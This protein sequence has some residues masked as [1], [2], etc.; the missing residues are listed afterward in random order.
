MASSKGVEDIEKSLPFQIR[1]WRVQ[2]VAWWILVLF[3]VAAFLGLLGR[4][5]PLSQAIVGDSQ[6][7]VR[8]E[9]ER[10]A[11]NQAPQELRL[12]MYVADAS[13]V[14]VHVWLS[15]RY[16]QVIE[17]NAVAPEPE[18]VRAAGQ[19]LIYTFSKEKGVAHVDATFF[20]KAHGFGPLQGQVGIP[21]RM[22]HDFYQF[23]YP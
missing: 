10:F 23:V 5:G 18:T 3:W 22:Q 16:L 6:S 13:Q 17:V 1:Q 11:R 7:P 20:V 14:Q 4:G 15:S 21:G 8:L 2:H 9:Y 12:H 19:G